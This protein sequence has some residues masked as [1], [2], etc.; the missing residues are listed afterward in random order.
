MGALLAQD[1]KNSQ[2]RI[3]LDQCDQRLRHFVKRGIALAQGERTQDL[4]DPLYRL[5]PQRRQLLCRCLKNSL[6]GGLQFSDVH[7]HA[8]FKQRPHLLAAAH[9]LATCQQQGLVRV[10]HIEGQ[11]DAHLQAVP[12]R[13]EF[14]EMH[15]APAGQGK[16]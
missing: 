8:A 9:D 16:G 15:G 5:P 7:Q 10:A 11:R 4:S 3:S 6:A 13:F 14:D 2:V 12:D 1:L